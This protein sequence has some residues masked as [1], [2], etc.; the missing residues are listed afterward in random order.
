MPL[1]SRLPTTSGSRCCTATP[2]T[3]KRAK[4]CASSRAAAQAALLPERDF[5]LFDYDLAATLLYGDDGSADHVETSSRP[6]VVV[7][8]RQARDKALPLSAPLA[9]YVREHQ[10]TTEGTKAA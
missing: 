3:W 8:L 1:A 9:E 6:S 4:T 7:L 5:W 10:I 2:P